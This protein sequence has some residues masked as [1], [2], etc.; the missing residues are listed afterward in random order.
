MAEIV[1]DDERYAATTTGPI[2]PGLV[3]LS[4]ICLLYPKPPEFLLIIPKNFS[5]NDFNS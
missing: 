4:L 1:L 5:A 3:T 2:D